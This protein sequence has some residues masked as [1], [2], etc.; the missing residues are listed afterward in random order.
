M[1]KSK[2]G[3]KDGMDSAWERLH[4]RDRR[5][6][7]FIFWVATALIGWSFVTTQLHDKEIPVM[8]QRLETNESEISI[9]R[10]LYARHE[11]ERNKHHT[12]SP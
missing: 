10:G 7:Q 11:A 6:G 12:H 1:A 8:K 2:D 4:T 3:G 5:I 9:L